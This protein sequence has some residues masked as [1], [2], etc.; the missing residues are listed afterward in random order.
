M[1][2]RFNL[3]PESFRSRGLKDTGSI[4]MVLI[5]S[6]YLLGLVGMGILYEK[7]LESLQDSLALLDF[8]KNQ[9]LFDERSADRTLVEI[10]GIQ[11]Q[12]RE[13]RRL[14][15]LLGN[16]VSG[17]ILWWKT[18]AQITHIV[19]EGVWLQSVSSTGEGFSRR[20][21]FRGHALSNQLVAR[22]L[23]LLEN[24]P[25][26]S[27]VGLEYSR[28]AKIGSHEVYSFEV[29]ATMEQSGGGS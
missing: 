8:Q 22:L 1:R 24:H 26:F 11:E 29:R 28:L 12:E 6:L 13:E 17:R 5:L 19:P 14:L 27:G 16:L 15:S 3:V 18:M 2:Y 25:D 21:V 23:F 10:L 20:M 7:R 4:L 9:L